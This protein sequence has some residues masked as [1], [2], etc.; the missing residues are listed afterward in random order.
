MNNN[1]KKELLKATLP[2]FHLKLKTQKQHNNSRTLVREYNTYTL[3]PDLFQNNY[4]ACV[5]TK[6]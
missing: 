5:N 6:A 4:N 1:D 2:T 3:L